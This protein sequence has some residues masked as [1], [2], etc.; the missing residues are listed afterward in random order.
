M[1]NL[2]GKTV[3]E[4]EVEIR[5]ELDRQ[6]I[7]SHGLSRLIACLFLRVEVLESRIKELE[8]GRP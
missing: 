6:K 8:D 5:E 7:K 4:L 3:P 1:I 2:D